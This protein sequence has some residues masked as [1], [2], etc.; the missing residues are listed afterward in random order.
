[1]RARKILEDAIQE[2][3]EED[4]EIDFT[5]A[6][7]WSAGEV[8]VDNRLCNVSYQNETAKLILP[9]AKYATPL[10]YFLFFF[11][12]LVTSTFMQEML[13]ILGLILLSMSV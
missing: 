8:Y 13:T 11:P 9:N 4:V 2:E 12:S 6:E 7:G 5:P 3:E 1:M 10:E